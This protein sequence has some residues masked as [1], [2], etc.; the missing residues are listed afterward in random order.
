MKE[1]VITNGLGGFASSTDL[2]GMN[3]RRYHGLLIAALEPPRNRTLILSKVDESIVIGKQEYILYTN[4][5]NG[6]KSEGYK[7]LDKF[8]KEIILDYFSYVLTKPSK[9]MF[10]DMLGRSVSMAIGF[11]PFKALLYNNEA[12]LY[13]QTLQIEN[14]KARA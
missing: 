12:Y 3:T 11:E 13:G 7:Y 8:E 6:V 5:T 1:W 10:V 9:G 4:E 14:L 2:G